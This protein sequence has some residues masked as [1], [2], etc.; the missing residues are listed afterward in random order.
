MVYHDPVLTIIMYR[1]VGLTNSDEYVSVSSAVCYS[2][3][4]GPESRDCL[5]HTC[6]MAG[7]CIFDT[8]I[9]C[10]LCI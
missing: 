6:G 9:I 1:G 10:L 3:I 8:Y 5:S 4:D 7:M 2:Y